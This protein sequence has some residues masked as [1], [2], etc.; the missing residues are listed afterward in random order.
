MEYYYSQN[1]SYYEV[2]SEIR[3]FSNISLPPISLQM[4]NSIA[5]SE[6]VILLIVSSFSI[7]NVYYTLISVLNL[8]SENVV[9]F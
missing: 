1:A 3:R 4:S 9:N 6:T 7:N 5:T 8:I 2:F